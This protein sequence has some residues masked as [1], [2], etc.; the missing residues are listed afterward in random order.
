M[1]AMVKY[2]LKLIEHHMPNG[3]LV[4]TNFMM[5]R[6][7]HKVWIPEDVGDN[8]KKVTII[9]VD[10]YP[11]HKSFFNFSLNDNENTARS[12]A[13]DI[14][15]SKWGSFSIELEGVNFSRNAQILLKSAFL[16]ML[17]MS[18]KGMNVYLGY[19]CFNKRNTA[20]EH[21]VKIDMIDS[22]E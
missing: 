9:G 19:K 6:Y 2:F 3:F 15:W 1:N 4:F 10:D 11:Y 7:G 13:F 8:F 14:S 12:S 20:Y 5:D 16:Q 22:V 17:N 21:L 18:N